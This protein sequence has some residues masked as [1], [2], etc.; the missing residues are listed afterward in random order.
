MKNLLTLFLFLPIIGLCTLKSFT[1]KDD[2]AYSIS[3]YDDNHDILTVSDISEKGKFK[4]LSSLLYSE[5]SDFDFLF[6]FDSL[7]LSSSNS[8][9][10]FNTINPHKLERLCTIPYVDLIAPL[11][12]SPVVDNNNLFLYSDKGTLKYSL[13]DIFSP[14]L[15]KSELN[16]SIT[17]F[18]EQS[19]K[20]Y[21]PL[22]YSMPPYSLSTNSYIYIDTTGCIYNDGINDN[23]FFS[24]NSFES[25]PSGFTLTDTGFVVVACK[26]D[27]IRIFK[28]DESYTNKL[29]QVTTRKTLGDARDV[30]YLNGRIYVADGV[31][32]IGF[33]DIDSYGLITYK[34]HHTLIS[35]SATS[36]KT[37]GSKIYA[38]C[39]EIMLVELS[40][41]YF[42]SGEVRVYKRNKDHGLFKK[43]ELI[44]DNLVIVSDE[45]G[46]K[47]EIKTDDK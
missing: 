26:S 5:K 10:L 30:A 23:R 45:L 17:N 39:E 8:V 24:T 38:T 9:V 6:N 44:S 42:N 18:Y 29:I 33:Y 41:D 22:M 35:G 19:D 11:T 7:Y 16:Y 37:N 20:M 43:I 40:P 46:N 25:T 2:L 12:N 21:L 36:I 1:I 14:V 15:I 4:K 27:G 32:G 47:V 31:N 34:G 28:F 13:D 3:E